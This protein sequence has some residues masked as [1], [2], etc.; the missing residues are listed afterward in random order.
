MRIAV[1]AMA[2]TSVTVLSDYGKGVIDADDS[3]FLFTAGLWT[4]SRSALAGLSF[5]PAV[6]LTE[7]DVRQRF[8]TPA[9]E[10]ALGGGGMVLLYPALGL[11]ATVGS[12]SRG[13]LEYVAPR[14]FEARLRAPLA[15]S[16]PAA[17]PAS[18]PV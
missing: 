4:Y 17:G 12:A 13:V 7:A 14:D 1:D 8:G 18:A 16:A 6:R 3:A 2:A 10:V 11:A 15:A 9:A 5:V